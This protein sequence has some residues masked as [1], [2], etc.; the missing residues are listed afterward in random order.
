MTFSPDHTPNREE[1][2]NAFADILCSIGDEKGDAHTAYMGFMDALD[3]HM[4][5]HASA[6]ERFLKLKEY[7]KK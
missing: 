3:L 5:Y 1:Y 6:R 2:K 4:T 7:M